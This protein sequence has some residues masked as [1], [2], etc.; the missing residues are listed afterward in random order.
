M[1][2]FLDTEEFEPQKHSHINHIMI[3][4]Q[5]SVYFVCSVFDPYI[6]S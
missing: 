3:I 6:K 5:C 1:C 2:G 4:N